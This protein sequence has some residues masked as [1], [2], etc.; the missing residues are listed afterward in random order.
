MAKGLKLINPVVTLTALRTSVSFSL[1]FLLSAV[2]SFDCFIKEGKVHPLIRAH[3][4]Q[5]FQSIIGFL[6][7][8]LDSSLSAICKYFVEIKL[9]NILLTMNKQMV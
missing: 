7:T 6:Y 5:F 1:F 2:T 8:K 9:I 4:S 3:V